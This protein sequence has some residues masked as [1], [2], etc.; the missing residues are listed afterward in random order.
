MGIA[1]VA[2]ADNRVAIAGRD[3]PASMSALLRPPVC[4]AVRYRVVALHI[5]QTAGGA[6]AISSTCTTR[7]GAEAAAL[8]GTKVCSRIRT[9][10]P[11]RLAL[12]RPPVLDAGGQAGGVAV[13]SAP[14]AAQARVTIQDPVTRG[15]GSGDTSSTC[16]MVAQYVTSFCEVLLSGSCQLAMRL[17]R[18]ALL[19][20][21][22]MR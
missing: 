13:A 7:P 11:R 14:Q 3:A 2:V 16:R 8:G 6:A 1:R 15:A 21:S 18:A 19:R 17:R 5:F 22:K 4:R 10:R 12:R 20:P 9:A